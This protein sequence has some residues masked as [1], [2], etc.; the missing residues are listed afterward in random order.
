MI[1]D[2]MGAEF[3]LKPSHPG[4]RLSVKPAGDPEMKIV[5]SL[6]VAGVAAR[7]IRK[8]ASD[9]VETYVKNLK[10]LFGTYFLYPFSKPIHQKHF[11]V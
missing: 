7:N 3:S 8:L 11:H 1:L 9:D 4:H 10:I 5:I 2:V 6:T